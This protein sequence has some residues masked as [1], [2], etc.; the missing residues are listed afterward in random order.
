MFVRAQV[1]VFMYQKVVYKTNVIW[2]FGTLLMAYVFLAHLLSKKPAVIKFK[3]RQQH[4]TCMCMCCIFSFH[5][6][7]TEC[8]RQMIIMR[9]R[10]LNF[11]EKRKWN[12]IKSTENR[13]SN[14]PWWSK[15][16]LDSCLMYDTLVYGDMKVVF[17]RFHRALCMSALR[18]RTGNEEW[19]FKT[20]EWLLERKSSTSTSVKRSRIFRLL[21]SI[22]KI[23]IY[24]RVA[25]QRS[26][27]ILGAFVIGLKSVCSSV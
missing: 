3:K 13:T 26:L 5:G 7:F 18:S 16:G 9:S 15:R 1:F 17:T 8:G 21:F 22:F 4:S 19:R 20:G 24:V 23:W 27:W 14:F 25:V 12:E 2:I 6:S 11:H 10:T